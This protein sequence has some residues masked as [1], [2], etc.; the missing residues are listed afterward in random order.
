M[1]NSSIWVLNKGRFGCI[2]SSAQAVAVHCS[3]SFWL[4]SICKVW[5]VAE[6]EALSDVICRAGDA[7]SRIFTALD[8]Q[9]QQALRESTQALEAAERR[10][11]AAAAL[12]QEAEQKARFW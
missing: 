11:A 4:H 5:E 6:G 9:S 12:A 3:Q 10:A 1:L 8:S 2:H 7:A